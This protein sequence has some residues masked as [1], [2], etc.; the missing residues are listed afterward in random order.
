VFGKVLTGIGTARPG[1]GVVLLPGIVAFTVFL[2]PLQAVSIDLGRDLGFTREID[3]RLLAPLPVDQVA[4]EKVL[5]AALRGLLAGAFVFPL[6]YWILGSGYQVRTDRVGVLAGMMVLTSLV[7]AATGLLLG[8]AVPITRLTLIFS[9]VITPLIFTGCTYYPW[10]SLEPIRWFQYLALVNPLTYAAEGCASRS[11]PP[12]PAGRRRRWRSV[13]CSSS[14]AG[15]WRSCWGSGCGCSAA[16]SSPDPA[17]RALLPVQPEDVPA[18]VRDR[19]VERADRPLEA[20]AG[21]RVGRDARDGL[22]LDADPEEPVDRPSEQGLRDPL[23]LGDPDAVRRSRPGRVSALI[24][25]GGSGSR[26]AIRGGSSPGPPPGGAL[27][28]RPSRLGASC[29]RGT[30]AL[31]GSHIPSLYGPVR[32]TT[33][34]SIAT[35]NGDWAQDVVVPSVDA[36]TRIGQPAASWTVAD[37]SPASSSQSLLTPHSPPAGS[38]AGTPRPA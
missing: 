14:C 13:G 26:L 31:L 25:T 3:D 8:T 30:S 18:Q 17:G 29:H 24:E 34:I 15:R 20:L 28:P 12:R 7:G 38:P 33:T 16:A 23:T 37:P 6:A 4:V 27:R 1:F 35:W 2:T 21:V 5:L 11:C 32:A 36:S 19:L 9:L 22:Q 10:A